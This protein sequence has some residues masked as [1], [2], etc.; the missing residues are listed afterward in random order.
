MHHSNIIHSMRNQFRRLAISTLLSKAV[1]LQRSSAQTV[2]GKGKLL[3]ALLIPDSGVVQIQGMDTRDPEN[4]ATICTQI[5]MI[6]QRPQDQ[7]VAT[8]VEEDVAFG[9]GNLGLT[10]DEIRG[11]VAFA[12]S[13][14]GLTTYRSKPSYLLSADEIQR[15]AS[16]GVLAMRPLCLIFD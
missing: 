10:A 12:L 6:F 4:H 13:T 1:N 9:S 8:T 3:N 16:A 14:S 2:R 5:G 15:L 7:I 11:S